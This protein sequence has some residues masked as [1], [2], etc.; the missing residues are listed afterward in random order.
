MRIRDGQCG[1]EALG[2]IG[3]D[4]CQ[5]KNDWRGGGWL[6]G[7]LG[8]SDEA[9]VGMI[10]CLAEAAVLGGEGGDSLA[11]GRGFGDGGFEAG[12]EFGK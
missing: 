7:G 6:R 10:E 4:L 11:K 3:R 5:A 8:D 9:S 2:D 12:V 1:R